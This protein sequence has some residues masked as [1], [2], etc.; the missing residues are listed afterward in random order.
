M[1]YRAKVVRRGGR[2]L[3][4]KY[5]RPTPRM[6][7]PQERRNARARCG[8]IMCLYSAIAEATPR[9]NACCPEKF[10]SRTDG[11]QLGA[12]KNLLKILREHVHVV[13]HSKS[14]CQSRS[15]VTQSNN[16]PHANWMSRKSAVQYT[17]IRQLLAEYPNKL[18]S[19]ATFV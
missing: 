2:V 3:H 13:M 4:L 14:R 18:N 15:L 17:C 1:Q 7:W 5:K 8:K 9:E 6:D 19:S 16:N 11:T 10:W 12:C